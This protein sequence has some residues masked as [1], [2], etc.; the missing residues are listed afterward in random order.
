M[1]SRT[2]RIGLISVFACLTLMLTSG[3]ARLPPGQNGLS[4]RRLKVRL[5]FANAVNPNYY[6]YF[7]INNSNN[8]FSPGPIPVGAPISNSSYGNGFATSSSTDTTQ[9]G[10]TDFVLFSN[11]TNQ[12]QY[13][14][15]QPREGYGL[16]HLV[17]TDENNRVNLRGIGAP[18]TFTSP[19]TNPDDPNSRVLYFEIDLSQIIRDANGNPLT[20]S[21]ASNMAQGIRFL[22]LNVVATNITPTDPTTTIPKVFDSFGD[23]RDG[24]GTFLNMDLSSPIVI[25]NND[26]NA[27]IE[28]QGDVAVSPP[29]SANG[30][31]TPL[32]LLTWSVELSQQ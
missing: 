21:Q 3:C 18:V 6:Y 28:I 24:R 29:G 13:P 11:P 19:T 9:R 22:Q 7:I 12:L 31:T 27:P 4:G 17:G 5:T 15:S 30:D 1:L 23:T 14:N 20:D 32:D 26:V 16:Y 8:R 2:P 25:H 10:F